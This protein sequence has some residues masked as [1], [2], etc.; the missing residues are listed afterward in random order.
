M[1]HHK[2][3][4]FIDQKQIYL[5][6]TKTMTEQEISNEI[7]ADLDRFKTNGKMAKLLND[8][9]RM[10][11]KN[12]ISKDVSYARCFD[13]VSESKNNWLF[14]LNKAPS[15][16][17]YKNVGDVNSPFLMHYESTKGVMFTKVT[18]SG[19]LD[20]YDSN[21]FNSYKDAMNLN[22]SNTIEIAKHFFMNNGYYS[23]GLIYI[24]DEEYALCK[25]KEGFLFGDISEDKKRIKM[26]SFISNDSSV[27]LNHI[28]NQIIDSLQ[29]SIE[30]QLNG[31]DLNREKYF[32]NADVSTNIRAA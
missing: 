21:F 3:A 7:F 9:H 20:Y 14:I 16:K 27:D 26:L 30:E 29:R 28:G 8:D 25:C 22:L 10:R 32:V 11:T 12:K 1:L 23:G 5:M 6:I 17:K 24:K 18:T 19:G 15:V 4:C 13:V 2:N 31:T